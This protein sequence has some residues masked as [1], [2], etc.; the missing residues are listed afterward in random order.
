MVEITPGARLLQQRLDWLDAGDEWYEK[1]KLHYEPASVGPWRI[2]NFDIDRLSPERLHTIVNEGDAR[3]PGWGTG[4]TRL[5]KQIG[6]SGKLQVWM[7]DSKAEILE[8][9]EFIRRAE[10]AGKKTPGYSVLING[11]GLG[12][13]V[14]AA[15]RNHAG[16]IDVVE[17]D[18]MIIKLVG[19]KFAG[20]ENVR[21]HHGDA[22]YYKWETGRFWHLV[23]H[24]IWPEIN[25]TNIPEMHYLHRKYGGRAGWQESWQREMCLDH[26]RHLMSEQ[27]I[28]QNLL[29]K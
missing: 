7:S 11:L 20:N 19:E 5:R 14:T 25:G 28:I 12:L 2:E 4:F 23:W 6:N 9:K 1:Y 29:G 18:P 24:D 10:Y 26:Y 22:R 13:A 8:H 15:L 27:A 17:I 21:I 16:L 3:D